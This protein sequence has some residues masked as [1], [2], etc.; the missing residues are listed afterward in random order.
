MSRLHKVKILTLFLIFPFLLPA[1][2]NTPQFKAVAF[3]TARNDLA[4]ISFV[5]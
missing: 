4:H 5:R 2:K 1:Q 3:F